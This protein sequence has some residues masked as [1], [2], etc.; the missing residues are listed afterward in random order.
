MA[1][2]VQLIAQ[3]GQ[4]ARVAARSLAT[5]PAARIDD[6]LRAM[7]DELL[8]AQDAIITANAAD[9]SAALANGQTPALVDRLTL[10]PK[11]LLAC[12]EGLRQVASLPH[13]VGQKIREWTQPNGL[14]IAKVRVPL[15]VIGFIYESRPNV[16]CDAAGL[17]LKSGNAVILRGGSEALRSNLAIATALARGLAKAGLPAHAVQ[18]V[19][20]TDRDTVRLLGEAVGVIDLLI[21]RGGKGLIEA[22]VKS[23]RVPVI[24]HYDGIC[25]LYV[26]R[27]ADLAMATEIAINGK[28][29]RPGVCNA[30]ETILVH[31]D[32][33]DT[34]LAQAGRALTERKVQLRAEPHALALLTQAGVPAT[35]ANADDFKTEFLALILAV[36]IVDGV[37]AAIEH[38]ET[39]GSHHTDTIVTRDS[40]TAEQFLAGVDSA[41]VLWNASTRF[42]DGYEFGFGAE[43]GISTDRLH[44]RGP[45]GLEE[46]TSYKYI[47]RGDG[48]IRQ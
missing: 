1:D 7:A 23:A 41:V 37:E 30:L 32:I 26:D 27:E 5:T 16:T 14:Q 29:S 38:I 46:L 45:M 43:I 24:K 44:A 15:G 10:T 6:A 21:P 12:A 36:K 31:R 8:A 22:V 4:Q 17:C 18:L 3:L 42:N 9:V 33:A 19:P 39:N 40:A 48:Q 28:C 20:V 34:F 47:V 2:L 13:P 11:R 35:V 25:T